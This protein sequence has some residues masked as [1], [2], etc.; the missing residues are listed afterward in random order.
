MPAEATVGRYQVLSLLGKG[1]MG[2]VYKARHVGTGAEVALKV[3]TV[4]GSELT[5]A[6]ARF[7]R[8]VQAQAK[9]SHENIVRI[10]DSGTA[11]NGLPWAALELVTGGDL[12]AGFGAESVELRAR[13]E[14]LRD[15][16][17]GIAYAHSRGIVHRDLKP[18]NVLIGTDGR[19]RVSDFGLA[20]MLDR[21]T[22]LT[23]EGQVLGT[24][25]YLSPEQSAGRETGPPTDVH[26]LGAMLYEAIVG[27]PPFK[28]AGSSLRLF[29]MIEQEPPPDPAAKARELGKAEP[30]YELA[31]VA[32]AA[33]V[34]DPAKRPTAQAFA[35]DLDL[36]LRGEKVKAH[37]PRVPGRSRRAAIVAAIGVTAAAFIILWTLTRVNDPD[38]NWIADQGAE[39]RERASK[40][41]AA[42]DELTLA[43]EA[44][45]K[46]WDEP[47]ARARAAVTAT[48]DSRVAALAG[49][50]ALEARLSALD[51]EAAWVRGEL[52]G[53]RRARARVLDLAR[54]D[55][56]AAEA[57]TVLG[58][59]VEAEEGDAAAA[60]RV[61][62]PL[63]TPARATLAKALALARTKRVTDA[64]AALA[65]AEKGGLQDPPRRAAV[66][67]AAGS[68]DKAAAALASVDRSRLLPIHVPAL[69]AE[70]KKALD[71][72]NGDRA[73]AAV[74]RAVQAA[75]GPIDKEQSGDFVKTALAASHRAS[76]KISMAR[77]KELQG[78]YRDTIRPFKLA[79]RVDPTVPVPREVGLLAASYGNLA[80]SFPEATVE[81]LEALCYAME[82]LPEETDLPSNVAHTAVKTY[83][84]GQIDLNAAVETITRARAT[85]K[86]GPVRLDI[87][88][89]MVSI[90]KSSHQH[91]QALALAERLLNEAPDRTWLLVTRADI[92]ME[93]GRRDE[94]RVA[95][96]SA[97]AR[98]PGSGK[99]HHVRG[100]LILHSGDPSDYD[101]A[102]EDLRLAAEDLR[103]TIA[104]RDIALD[105]L[106]NLEEKRGRFA[107]A[108]EASERRA[109][110][111]RGES[112]GACVTHA[113]LLARAGKNDEAI[114]RLE[115]GAKT[116]HE[117][118]ERADL[119]KLVGIV[120]ESKD[121]V[122]ALT[123]TR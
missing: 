56:H 98:D 73:Q 111:D 44:H 122:A 41:T 32:L 24:P 81:C 107:Q 67:V 45:G 106:V 87:D 65:T 97:I 21:A 43:V 75:H 46:A 13:V 27:Q 90:L 78:N 30:P 121:P 89:E 95:L 36:W 94:A 55:A 57:A 83:E 68:L 25:N 69:L 86:P 1:G 99:A 6:R 16:A 74:D 49:A 100:S 3:L 116:M 54:L 58:A 18:Q 62:E 59:L 115:R 17:R 37:R 34:K 38:G 84:M 118:K 26:A 77:P 61:L 48:L 120:R 28:A 12:A 15:T 76:A 117:E 82:A 52:D 66:L 70:A 60:L 101:L 71:S 110:S 123:I 88:E 5:E 8:E 79:R 108:L 80:K 40:A 19:A 102:A 4:E 20:R 11:Q 113:R 23:R 53:A 91:A 105:F 112:L 2:A 92:L 10:L 35:D 103:E 104:Q 7:E 96:D 47:R 85:L 50:P 42:L 93:L 22:R 31:T 9:L 119:T 33:L 51:G 64:L 114:A 109:R 29:A 14:L 39:A 72:E 63:A